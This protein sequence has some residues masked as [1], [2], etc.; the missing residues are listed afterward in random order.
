VLWQRIGAL[1]DRY[2]WIAKTL[3]VTFVDPSSWV[4]NLDFS[5]DELHIDQNGVRRLSELYSRVCG[6]SSRG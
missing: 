1:N 5:G 4:E 3:G 2:N 6:F